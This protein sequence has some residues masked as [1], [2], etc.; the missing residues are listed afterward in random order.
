MVNEF[1]RAARLSS[2][3]ENK[4]YSIALIR[5]RFL[6][7]GFPEKQVARASHKALQPPQY[8]PKPKNVYIKMP[9]VDDRCADEL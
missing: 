6:N 8:G 1:R 3:H 4:E 7:N 5:N 9:F 2:S